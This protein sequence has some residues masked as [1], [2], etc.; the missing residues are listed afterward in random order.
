LGSQQSTRVNA[1]SQRVWNRIDQRG[2]LHT[3]RTQRDRNAGAE[4]ALEVAPIDGLGASPRV[5]VTEQCRAKGVKRKKKIESTN[6]IRFNNS[7]A[8]FQTF[9]SYN[10][11]AQ[12]SH[13]TDD[14]ASITHISIPHDRHF[15]ARARNRTDAARMRLDA[16][17]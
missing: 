3:A 5:K 13:H 14:S 9:S 6:E 7:Y 1:Q 12:F 15:E 10:S 11:Y 8:E 16:A 2:L 4:V 17:A